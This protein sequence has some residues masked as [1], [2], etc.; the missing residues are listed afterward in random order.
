MTD[1]AAARHDDTAAVAR[2]CG[3]VSDYVENVGDMC[4][5]CRRPRTEAVPVP[6]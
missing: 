5:A 1:H 6:D 3:C 4:H 2:R